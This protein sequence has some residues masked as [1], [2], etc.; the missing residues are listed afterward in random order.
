MVREHALPINLA[1]IGHGP[2]TRGDLGFHP[3]PQAALETPRGLAR[4]APGL[5]FKLVR[6]GPVRPGSLQA[7]VTWVFA[8]RRERD[9]DIFRERAYVC[10]GEEL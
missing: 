8:R 1:L 10:G 5:R 6:H 7:A 9:P 2:C 3:P 4:P